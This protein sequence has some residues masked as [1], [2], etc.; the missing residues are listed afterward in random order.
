MKIVLWAG[1]LA[2]A[3]TGVLIVIAR[4]VGLHSSPGMWAGA[5]GLPGVVIANWLQSAI[6]HTFFRPL[7]YSLM[8]LINWGFYCSVIQGIVALRSKIAM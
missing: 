7:G 6:F 3:W 5:I 1:A 8:F 2:A 4:T